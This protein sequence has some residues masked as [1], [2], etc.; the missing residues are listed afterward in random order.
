MA[1]IAPIGRNQFI[2][3]MNS[4]GT[5]SL[6]S[7]ISEVAR[8]K[9]ACITITNSFHK[10]SIAN[11]MYLGTFSITSIIFSRKVRISLLDIHLVHRSTSR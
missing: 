6:G 9:A 4:G 5:G 8:S 7:S 11:S 2:S 3:C 1:I 10:V